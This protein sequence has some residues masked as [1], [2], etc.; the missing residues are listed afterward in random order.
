MGSNGH[1]WAVL[2]SA[3]AATSEHRTR[4]IFHTA[5]LTPPCLNECYWC[6]INFSTSDSLWA[7][8]A[9]R[10]EI[11]NKSKLLRFI[12]ECCLPQG[13]FMGEGGS[14]IIA[15]GLVLIAPIKDA[16]HGQDLIKDCHR[17][18]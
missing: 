12:F 3:A 10:I 15:Q 4:T 5:S 11:S 1:Q 6:Q 18:N 9:P 17:A 8:H 16:E 7:S 14:V 13:S 2:S